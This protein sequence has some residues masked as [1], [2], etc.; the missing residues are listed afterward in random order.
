MLKNRII[1]FDLDGTLIDSAPDVCLALNKVLT[2]YGRRPHSV[3]ETK[4]YLGK[5]ARILMEKALA[6]T[7]DV[8][9]ASEIERLT[10]A[11][12]DDYAENPVVESCIFPGVEKALA[13]LRDAGAALG[14]CTNKPSITA[15][16]VLE[17]LGLNERFDV[18]LC[19]DQVENQK[20]HGQHILDTAARF[21][22][23]DAAQTLM[24]GD[25]ENDIHAAI[26]AG[27]PSIAVSFGYAG[28]APDTLG[29]DMVIDH[30]DQLVEAVDIVLATANET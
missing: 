4:G 13:E 21:G 11:F 15:A 7:G 22:S 5:G 17:R 19:G 6:H 29:A 8:P 27:V 3:D 10:R 26:D 14:I 20:P 24:V 12:L 16:P 1:L 28:C 9:E 2:A 25:S 18:V 30:F 23:V